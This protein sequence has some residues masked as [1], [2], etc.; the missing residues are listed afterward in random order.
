[1]SLADLLVNTNHPW[2]KIYLESVQA[3]SITTTDLSATNLTVP[4]IDST[5]V[6]ATNIQGR[7]SGTPQVAQIRV[8][9]VGD[10]AQKVA[11]VWATNVGSV[12]VKTNNI[13]VNNLFATN[14][15]S[16]SNKV[17]LEYVNQIVVDTLSVVSS[18]V[19]ANAGIQLNGYVMTTFYT[20]YPFNM[21]ISSGFLN[22]KIDLTARIYG[23]QNQFTINLNEFTVSSS[24]M[25]GSDDR[26]YFEIPYLQSYA[27]SGT[28][29]FSTSN[30]PDANNLAVVYKQAG[31][32]TVSF[33]PIA[34]RNFSYSTYAGQ[35]LYFRVGVIN[36]AEF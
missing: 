13:N 7:G 31:T 27:M 21:S 19:F 14:V 23:I 2:A 17:S 35:D 34:T 1:M 12:A 32:S 8:A 20:E 29:P 5:V 36:C 4:A 24:Y 33:A 15:G 18:P 16:P 25:T 22:Q 11:D 26:F 10:P 30:D 28:V 3:S 9:T 6:K